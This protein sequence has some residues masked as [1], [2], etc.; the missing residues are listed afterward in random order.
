MLYRATIV[1]FPSQEF[2]LRFTMKR[3]ADQNPLPWEDAVLFTSLKLIMRKEIYL[4]WQSWLSV[5]WPRRTKGRSSSVGTHN[6]ADSRI[7]TRFTMSIHHRSRMLPW[8]GKHKRHEQIHWPVKS[9]T[10][11]KL[12]FRWNLE[13]LRSV[14]R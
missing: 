10:L 11:G 6:S 5:S 3:G 12:G 7:S 14:W 9:L 1:I 8:L 13:Y 4:E 2:L